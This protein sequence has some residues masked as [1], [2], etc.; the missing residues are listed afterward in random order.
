MPKML[1]VSFLLAIFAAH[2]CPS[3]LAQDALWERYTQAGTEAA[4]RNDFPL[5]ESSFQAALH[6]AEKFNTDDK[7]RATS[8]DNVADT[9]YKAG[10]FADA[11]P[12]YKKSI[13]CLQRCVTRDALMRP[14]QDEQLKLK[15]EL[16]NELS[17]LADCY[18]AETKYF[19]AEQTYRQAVATTN[20]TDQDAQ[21]QKAIVKS[22]LGDV[23]SLQNKFDEAEKLYKESLPVFEKAH[24]DRLTLDLLEDY[25]ALLR[26]TKRS[27]EADAMEDRIKTIHPAPAKQ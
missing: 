16:I 13:A 9:K 1:R 14:G 5:A 2:C 6:R 4:K 22:R 21:V 3:A 20:G 11:E 10:H 18:R 23:L 24:N 7:V 8:Y 19:E 17:D 12:Y 27:K 15:R 26:M 25:D